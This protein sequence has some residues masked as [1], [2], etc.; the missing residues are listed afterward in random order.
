[1]TSLSIGHFYAIRYKS[2]LIEIYQRGEVSRFFIDQVEVMMKPLT[3]LCLGLLLIALNFP[4]RAGWDIHRLPGGVPLEIVIVDEGSLEGVWIV[5]KQS[6]MNWLPWDATNDEWEDEYIEEFDAYYYWFTGA[7]E[8]LISVG[9]PYTIAATYQGTHRY[10]YDSGWHHI[11]IYHFVSNGYNRWHDA[12]FFEDPTPSRGLSSQNF[13]VSNVSE[14]EDG[15]IKGLYYTTSGGTG[16]NA[17]HP[18]D[19]SR[20][21]YKDIY[22]DLYDAT[23]L[24]TIREDVC[25]FQ[26]I[27]FYEDAYHSHPSSTLYEITAFYQYIED[28][29]DPGTDI[30][31]QFL[32]ANQSEEEEPPIWDVWH[33]SDSGGGFSNWNPICTDVD[34]EFAG[35]FGWNAMVAY[36]VDAATDYWYIYLLVEQHGLVLLKV[37]DGVPGTV[38]SKKYLN[39][40]TSSPEEYL[41]NYSSRSLNINTFMDNYPGGS[42]EELL[43]GMGQAGFRMVQVSDPT[44]T[45]SVSNIYDVDGWGLDPK[46]HGSGL[47]GGG[48]GRGVFTKG[49]DVYYMGKFC[50]VYKVETDPWLTYSKMGIATPQSASWDYISKNADFYHDW[51]CGTPSPF[52]S[53]YVYL[54]GGF[55]DHYWESG[56]TVTLKSGLSPI[57][58]LDVSSTTN[59]LTPAST[60]WKNSLS[61]N[62][63]SYI[64][65]METQSIGNND[66]VYIAGAAVMKQDNRD[67]SKIFVGQADDESLTVI[68]NTTTMREQHTV[69]SWLG[70]YTGFDATFTELVLHPNVEGVVYG[71]G[72]NVNHMDWG[73]EYG[74]T[75]QHPNPLTELG[76]GLGYVYKD[77]NSWIVEEIIPTDYS[78]LDPIPWYQDLEY[79]ETVQDIV[80][81]ESSDPTVTGHQKVDM[82]VACGVYPISHKSEDIPRYGGIF[83]VYYDNIADEN[84]W[85]VNNITP[86][87]SLYKSTTSSASFTPAGLATAKVVAGNDIYYFCTTCG[88][89]ASS[90]DEWL[91]HIWYQKR[92]NIRSL[93]QAG[94][95]K[96]RWGASE[97]GR[98]PY[99]DGSGNYMVTPYKYL[100]VQYESSGPQYFDTF[101]LI[102]GNYAYKL[103]IEEET[104]SIEGCET[105]SGSIVLDASVTIDSLDTLI[106]APDCNLSIDGDLTV[107]DGG[108]LIVKPGAEVYFGE[109]HE[110]H[111]EGKLTA[112]GKVGA[113]STI[114]FAAIDPSEGWSGIKV[115]HYGKNPAS[116]SEIKYCNISEAD[117]GI[118][119]RATSNLVI[120]NCTIED[121]VNGIYCSAPSAGGVNPKIRKNTISN[122]SVY[123]IG[124]ANLGTSAEILENTLEENDDGNVYLNNS[125]PYKYGDNVHNGPADFGL[126]CDGYSSPWMN[127]SSSDTENGYNSFSDNT[128]GI[129]V[130][131]TAKPNLGKWEAGT[132]EE[133]GYNNFGSHTSYMLD[134]RHTFTLYAEV[135]YWNGEEIDT[136][137]VSHPQY[138]ECDSCL[139]EPASRSE[140]FLPGSGPIAKG[141][142]QGQIDGLT[143]LLLEA[144]VLLYTGNPSGA[145]SLYQQVLSGSPTEEEGIWAVWGINEANQLIGISSS[146]ITQLQGISGQFS[147]NAIGTF[148]QYLAMSNTATMNPSSAL[149]MAFN[150]AN[151]SIAPDLAKQALFQMALLEKYALGNPEAGDSLFTLFIE[152]Y[153]AEELAN[154]AYLELGLTPP[155][156]AGEGNGGMSGIN[157]LP[158]DYAFYPNYPNPFN[159][160]TTFRFSLPCMSKITMDV[161]NVM[162]RKVATL[163]DEVKAAGEYRVV[164]NTS[165]SNNTVLASGMYFCR[166]KARSTQTNDRFEKV[167]KVLLLK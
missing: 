147:T 122:N 161:Y 11:P 50:G 9:H 117:K 136:T 1:V 141:G 142:Q 137:V 36:F 118:W 80:V 115:N 84:V 32:L 105:W 153:P 93:T 154:L 96:L 81:E 124:A 61:T 82:L 47:M 24:Y 18:A 16:A 25:E 88:E 66:N 112:V 131:E 59:A 130:D 51:G 119:A 140:W 109:D 15:D 44:G 19:N 87:P 69:Y 83:S 10:E 5:D 151:Q 53:D 23:L 95:K 6:G 126:Y 116:D 54:G 139:D 8:L 37:Q 150:L 107:N 71:S 75:Q 64:S 160:A 143:D 159:A 97:L 111:V 20:G 13:I 110:L 56:G 22:R 167:Q 21:Y 121:N 72:L 100:V 62:N 123:G 98:I 132:C 114:I 40:D 55:P 52:N 152:E 163:V 86:S 65:R 120:E 49:T 43:V 94:W 14:L 77:N 12:A 48:G 74:S 79:F 164:W 46:G 125:S 33:R 60:Q 70:E 148:A 41:P 58:K 85:V 7:D 144:D 158:E 39:Y 42:T 3:K 92:V 90:S 165:K 68:A 106:L 63:I 73:E 127:Y 149:T 45:P 4:A 129:I 29:P 166:I 156:V 101:K 134:N 113:D 138:V 162:G 157:A 89:K 128:I 146:F 26:K 34:D 78:E 76:G 155:Q 67:P 108:T 27:D 57:W 35:G 135:N 2:K 28:I 145:A 102:M 17:W 104:P 103:Q 133:P 91:G 99:D 31:H 38:V 30:Y